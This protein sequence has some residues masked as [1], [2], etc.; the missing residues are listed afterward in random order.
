ME[1]MLSDKN[2]SEPTM[3]C[4]YSTGYWYKYHTEKTDVP[5]TANNVVP[6]FRVPCVTGMDAN[7]RTKVQML[8]VRV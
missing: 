5:G 1:K 3:Q 6:V 7:R 8:L 2:V 4:N